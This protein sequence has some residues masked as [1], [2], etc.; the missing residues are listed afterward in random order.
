MQ[1]KENVVL[2]REI[3]NHALKNSS[4]Y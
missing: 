1:K 4:F 2:H 3:F